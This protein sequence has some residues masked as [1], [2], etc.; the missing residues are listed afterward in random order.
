MLLSWLTIAEV[1]TFVPTKKNNFLSIMSVVPC[2][3]CLLCN[4]YIWKHSFIFK[5]IKNQI[6]I[7]FLLLNT[8]QEW[9]YQWHKPRDQLYYLQST[10]FHWSL[11]LW[12]LC[13]LSVHLL[14]KTN[15][16]AKKQKEGNLLEIERE[17]QTVLTVVNT[18]N[19]HKPVELGKAY[20]MTILCQFI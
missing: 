3:Q 8:Y 19:L 15:L 2:C 9:L 11:V 17:N 13:C 18:T 7:T 12:N 16:F 14:A 4:G 5:L 1:V 10:R 6:S 20:R